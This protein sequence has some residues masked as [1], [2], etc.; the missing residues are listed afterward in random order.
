MQAYLRYVD[1]VI[2]VEL[3]YSYYAET[4]LMK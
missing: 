1:R 4:L 3:R 2:F